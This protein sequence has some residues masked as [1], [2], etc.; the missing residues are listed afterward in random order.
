M[1][2]VL[3]PTNDL[4]MQ[5]TEDELNELNMAPGDKFDCKIQ[6]DGSIKLSK[7]VKLELD[8]EEWP[9]TVLENIIKESCERDISVNE[10][11]SDMLKE[12]L[13]LVE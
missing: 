9:R 5:F 2:K 8:M 13:K 10:V 11:I 1:K 7:Y 12:G 4:Y 6:D 3:L